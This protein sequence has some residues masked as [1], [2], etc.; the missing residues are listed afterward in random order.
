VARLVLVAELIDVWKAT[1]FFI[2]A[3]S[4]ATQTPKTKSQIVQ[5]W[6][7]S[8]SFNWISLPSW[9]GEGN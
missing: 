9:M 6:Q 2:A 1:K 8:A 3:G 7:I 5:K 4:N